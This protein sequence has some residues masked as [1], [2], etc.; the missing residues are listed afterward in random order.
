VLITL[1]DHGFDMGLVLSPFASADLILKESSAGACDDDKEKRPFGVE[2][3]PTLG[4]T[5]AG[6]A[7]DVDDP[8]NPIFSTQLAVSLVYVIDYGIVY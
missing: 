4:I 1:T 7:V 2:I 8:N 3:D 6:D 5:L